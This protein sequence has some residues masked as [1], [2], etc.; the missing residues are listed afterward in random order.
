MEWHDWDWLLDFGYR[1]QWVRRRRKKGGRGGR[2]VKEFHLPDRTVGLLQD[3]IFWYQELFSKGVGKVLRSDAWKKKSQNSTWWGLSPV[4][5]NASFKFLTWQQKCLVG[6]EKGR[7]EGEG[8]EPLPR[9][10]LGLSCSLLSPPLFLPSPSSAAERIRTTF[11]PTTPTSSSSS[12][13][14]YKWV[15]LPAAITKKRHQ[16]IFFF[17]GGGVGEEKVFYSPKFVVLSRKKN[18]NTSFK[19]HSNT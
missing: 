16:V 1:G 9:V 8:V 19:K 15:Q 5:L 3:Q 17:G 13:L 7:L 10:P 4:L 11:S 6:Q 14:T 12:F 2:S 18:R